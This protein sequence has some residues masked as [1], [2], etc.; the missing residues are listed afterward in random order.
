MR[1]TESNLRLI[2]REALATSEQP[3]TIDD[4]EQRHFGL[5]SETV[6]KIVDM[7]M[8]TKPAFDLTA[9]K[10]KKIFDMFKKNIKMFFSISIRGYN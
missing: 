10:I 6:G 7:I 5:T 1:I 3:D 2:I 8:L 9:G 4:M